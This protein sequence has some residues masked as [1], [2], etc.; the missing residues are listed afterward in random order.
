MIKNLQPFS[1]TLLLSLSGYYGYAALNDAVSVD[2]QPYLQKATLH[3]VD[4]L[5]Q[6]KA[7][8]RGCVTYER[9]GIRNRIC[10]PVPRYRHDI[11]LSGL[12]SDTTYRYRVDSPSLKIDN[13]DRSFTTLCN[14]PG[15]V[16][17]TWIIGDSG[18]PGA[19][20]QE[21]K[22]AMLSYLGDVAPDTWILLGDIAYRSG[23]QDEFNTDFFEAY[24]EMI[25][26]NPVWVAAGNHDLG[27][28]AFYRIF[29]MPTGGESGGVA[30]DDPRF[31]AF[32]N[33]NVH[34][35]ILDSQSCDL[36]PDGAMARWLRKDLEGNRQLWT[37][38]AFHHPPYSRGSHDSDDLKASGGR[39]GNV[40]NAIVP[41]LERYD[42]D[43]VLSG[44]SHTYERSLLSHGQYGSST[45]FDAA[46]HVVEKQ[47]HDYTK[48][49]EKVPYQGTLYIVDGAS[50]KS[51]GALSSSPHPMMPIR[52]SRSGSLLLTVDHNR[53]S[54]EYVTRNGEVFDRFSI[55]K[56]SKKKT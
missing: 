25:K 15:R 11:T 30:S 12:E 33:G 40:R 56:E 28:D 17:R 23:T 41:I 32:D 26:H 43:L 3:G 22:T 16:Q 8:E 38:V 52:T 31:Y 51:S 35:V 46:K 50:A 14:D 19:P 4:V 6:T 29:S 13:T 37:V 10:E 39:L 2:R 47:R 9:E 7:K 45:T 1:L 5:W 53:L 49:A 21:V 27:S 18:I 20:Q 24:S 36:G 55:E 44:H 34:Y 54:G 42:V 48:Q